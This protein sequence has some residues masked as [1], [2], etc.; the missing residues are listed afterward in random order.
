MGCAMGLNH[1]SAAGATLLGAS[2]SHMLNDAVPQIQIALIPVF[3]KEFNLTIFQAGLMVSIP[4]LCSTVSI[5]FAGLLADRVDHV[6]QI[7]MAL[8]LMAVSS[9]LLGFTRSVS[10]LTAILSA[11]LV[12]N[13][14]F[15]PAGFTL[16]SGVMSSDRRTTAL[17]F[18]NAGGIMGFAL[19][20]FS[21]GALLGRFQWRTIYLVWT[22]ILIFTIAYMLTLKWRKT[23]KPQLK[24]AEPQSDRPSVRSILALPFI[25]LIVIVG[26]EWM[27]RHMIL[28]YLTSFLVF[29]RNF[30]VQLASVFLGLIS[31]VGI[32]GGPLGGYIADRFGVVKWFMICIGG[33]AACTYLIL[34]LTHLWHLTA[35]T[36]MFGFFAA[37]E[38]ASASSLVSDYVHTSRRG[39]GYSLYFLAINGVSTIAP[40]TGALIAEGHG[41][42][43]VFYGSMTLMIFA[44]A[45]VWLTL[46]KQ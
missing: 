32:L 29:D 34:S 3:M 22:V 15:H 33:L 37:G 26:L 46:K 35:V 12:G 25:T 21:V 19:G 6:N 41:F 4:L 42:P 28:T 20:P 9:I 44:L 16:S 23:Y 36:L 31:V 14:L 38:M 18:F 7:V 40:L 2:L 45:M 13:S 10:L 17:G 43:A 27:G 5:V 1:H 8:S 24:E 39:L 30:T 11:I